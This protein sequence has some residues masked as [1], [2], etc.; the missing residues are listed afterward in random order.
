MKDHQGALEALAQVP[1]S[2]NRRAEAMV[3][4]GRIRLLAGQQ[5][6]EENE[7]GDPVTSEESTALFHEAIAIFEEASLNDTLAAQARRK[8]AYLTGKAYRYLGELQKSREQLLMA[9]RLFAGSPEAYAA[10]LELAE[11]NLEAGR[12]QRSLCGF[13]HAAARNSLATCVSQSLAYPGR[14]APP[15]GRGGQSYGRAIEL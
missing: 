11:V 14:A 10:E 3:H 6:M 13:P 5:M 8:S 9:T 2:S 7:Q 4:L 15:D 12:G 1:E